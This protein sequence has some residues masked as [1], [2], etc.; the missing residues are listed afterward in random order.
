MKK[1]NT[2]SIL[3]LSLVLLISC[4][5]DKNNSDPT[6]VT[7]AP[8]DTYNPAPAGGGYYFAKKNTSSELC[9]TKNFSDF[10]LFS[11]KL[12]NVTTFGFGKDT[13]VVFQDWNIYFG[14]IYNPSDM[15]TITCSRYVQYLSCINNVV[16]CYAIDGNNYYLGYCDYKNGERE[17]TFNFLN[18]GETITSPIQHTGSELIAGGY[19]SSVSTPFLAV[20]KNGKN[21]SYKGVPSSFPTYND[22]IFKNYNNTYYALN[23]FT[24]RTTTDT[25]FA[26]GSWSNNIINFWPNTSDTIGSYQSEFLHKD[27]SNWV[28][29]GCIASVASGK[30]IPAK[31]TSTDNGAT[32]TTTLL[33]GLPLEQYFYAVTKTHALAIVYD[34]VA[35]NGTYKT[36]ISS[37]FVN[38]S[39]TTILN[40]DPNVFKNS[41]YFE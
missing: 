22:A 40:I 16:V 14:N 13:F 8:V 12:K 23:K 27:G 15:K 26:S 20:T 18:N 11:S 35:N 2:L 24:I 30:Y 28:S 34:N 29:Y 25:S 17:I 4:K 41:N 32:F 33:T 39:Q 7:P 9:W 10:N 37:D 3:I 36:Y 5:K 1:L 31:N 38:F 21:W 19:N 6:P